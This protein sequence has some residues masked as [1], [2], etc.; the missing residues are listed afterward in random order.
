M[1]ANGTPQLAAVLYTDSVESESTGSL[2]PSV[3]DACYLVRAALF[4]APRDDDSVTGAHF[5]AAHSLP[6]S[7]FSFRC[8]FNGCTR[9]QRQA[10]APL[11]ISR[12]SSLVHAYEPR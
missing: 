10:S 11:Y 5:V 9:T 3:K 7:L 8:I 6:P 1:T 2:E 4:D 12:P